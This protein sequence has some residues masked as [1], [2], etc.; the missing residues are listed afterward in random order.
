MLLGKIS[1]TMKRAC[2][3]KRRWLAN[4]SDGGL[5]GGRPAPQ[6]RGPRGEHGGERER[7]RPWG[8]VNAWGGLAAAP[9]ACE[10][11]QRGQLGEVSWLS[12]VVWAS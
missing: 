4:P 5:R 8:R 6:A 2:P 1:S 9:G 3:G 12:G 11:A 10:P 7:R